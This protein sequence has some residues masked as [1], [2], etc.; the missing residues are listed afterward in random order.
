[1]TR[2]ELIVIGCSWGGLEALGVILGALP[3]QFALPI[4]VAQHRAPS[5]SDSTLTA[6]LGARS[7]P[8]V[9]AVEDK[10]PIAAGGGV[11]LAPP[12]YHLLV[13]R[14][15]FALSIDERVAYSRPSVDVLFESATDAYGAAVIGVVLTGANADGAVG[16]ARVRRHGGHGIVQ[17]PDGAARSAMPAAA[18]A[19]GGADEVLPLAV[20]ARR[21]S[22]WPTRPIEVK[23]DP[24]GGPD[25][26]GR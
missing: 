17:D 18:I 14:G 16:L 7:G 8:R 1:M 10:D 20:S 9:Q 5:S 25:T 23:H 21:S 3:R 22:P 12:D 26:D 4:A 11:Y 2:F 15:S 6:V 13:E 24:R 19:A